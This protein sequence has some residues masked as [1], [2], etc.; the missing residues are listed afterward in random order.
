MPNF[1]PDYVAFLL[2]LAGSSAGLGF[3]LG[4]F[5]GRRSGWDSAIAQLDRALHGEAGPQ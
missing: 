5:V 4:F 3:L 1:S 2:L